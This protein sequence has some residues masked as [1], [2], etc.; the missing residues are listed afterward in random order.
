MPR[1]TDCG[2]ADALPSVKLF[3]ASTGWPYKPRWSPQSPLIFITGGAEEEPAFATGSR[4]VCKRYKDML[5]EIAKKEHDDIFVVDLSQVASKSGWRSEMQKP[6]PASKTLSKWFMK[7]NPSQSVIVTYGADV[8]LVEAMLRSWSTPCTSPVESPVEKIIVVGQPDKKTLESISDLA[9]ID[10]VKPSVQ[11]IKAKVMRGS[12]RERGSRQPDL[13]DFHFVSVEFSLDPTEKSL[14]QK[15]VNIT[16]MVLSG[17]AV[18]ALPTR[19]AAEAK[20]R[21][22]QKVATHHLDF[23]MIVDNLVVQVIRIEDADAMLNVTLADAHG[24]IEALARKV[25]NQDFELGKVVT[26]SGQVV[27]MQGRRILLVEN[28]SQSEQQCL[29][30]G[31][32]SVR[33]GQRNA[34]R[35]NHYSGCLVVKGSKCLLVRKDGAMHMPFTEPMACESKQQASTRAVK[36]ACKIYTEEFALLHD[37]PA[38]ISYEKRDEEL[39]VYTAHLAIATSSPASDAGGCGCEEQLDKE[40]MLYDWYTFEEAIA[41]LKDAPEKKCLVNLTWSLVEALDAGVVVSDHAVIFRPKVAAIG[42]EWKVDIA[43]DKPLPMLK[44]SGPTTAPSMGFKSQFKCE[45]VP[46]TSLSKRQQAKEK[47]MQKSCCGGACGPKGCC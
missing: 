11:A 17:G 1:K 24:S 8:K 29:P 39:A 28:S 33:L 10:V 44:T 3:V 12:D 22:S 7:F 37:V 13:V 4:H 46:T 32:A 38:A 42:N 43:L 47:C 2:N 34:S 30:H 15:P 19:E 35:R 6:G 23:G 45:R 18:T 16:S 20:L 14:V 40:A 21:N 5:R 27:S 36:E 31:Y 26:V 25:P 9:Q 41:L